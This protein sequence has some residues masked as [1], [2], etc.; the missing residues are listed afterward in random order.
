MQHIM[1]PLPV[2][3]EHEYFSV[4]QQQPHQQLS[5]HFAALA[6]ALATLYVCH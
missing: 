2:S 5:P 3:T 1:Q 6:S 4:Q